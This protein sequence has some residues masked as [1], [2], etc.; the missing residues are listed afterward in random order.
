MFMEDVTLDLKTGIAKSINLNRTF[1]I[2]TINKTAA[3]QY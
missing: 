2:V 3:S 1:P